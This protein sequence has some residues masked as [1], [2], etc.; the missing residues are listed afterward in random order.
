MFE[1]SGVAENVAAGL[2]GHEH[3]TM[4]FGLY[5]GGA[6]LKV[7]AAAIAQLDYPATA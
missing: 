2:L 6:S 1:N 7:K 5:S 4:T 3:P